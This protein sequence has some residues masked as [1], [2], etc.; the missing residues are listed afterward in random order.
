MAQ[1]Y[2]LEN[3]ISFLD[4]VSPSAFFCEWL[5]RKINEYTCHEGKNI[6]LKKKNQN[7]RD[8]KKTRFSKLTILEKISRKFH[9]LVLELVVLIYAKGIDVAQPIWS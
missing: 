8:S 4:I 7:G 3:D 6:F 9:G 2:F 5:N 1:R